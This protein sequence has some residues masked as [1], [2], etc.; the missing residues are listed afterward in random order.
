MCVICNDGSTLFCIVSET[1]RYRS[2]ISGS[3]PTTTFSPKKASLA[4]K[5]DYAYVHLLLA[6]PKQCNTLEALQWFQTIGP[7]QERCLVEFPRVLLPSFQH[8]LEAL[9]QMSKAPDVP[10]VDLIAPD[11]QQAGLVDVPPPRYATKPNFVF[12]LSSLT[13]GT[14]LQCGP[15]Q[16]LD[17]KV[18]SQHSTLDPTQSAALLDS[19]SKGLALIQGPP[20]TGKSYTG[21]KLIE[22]LLQNKDH[23]GAELGPILCVCYTNH[24]LDQLLEHLIDKCGVGQVIRIGSRSKSSRLTGFNLHTISKTADRTR[25]ENFALRGIYGNLDSHVGSLQAYLD[26]L[27]TCL[28]KTAILAYLAENHPQHHAKLSD[29]DEVDDEGFQTVYSRPQQRMYQWLYGG[30]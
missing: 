17:P 7:H 21:E 1:T 28:S 30:K 22:V 14:P 16:P 11:Q 20:G 13:N 4:D 24:A 6:D 23:A 26:Q 15:H 12:D 2:G 18:L 19:L 10:F 9:Q 29:D 3:L 8:T 5:A 25:S 27:E